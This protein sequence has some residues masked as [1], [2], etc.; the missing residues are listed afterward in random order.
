MEKRQLGSSD[1]VISPI[2]MGTWQAGKDMW[3]D[4]DDQTS[5]AAIRA[6]FDSGITTFDTAERYGNGHA[7]RI[8]AKALKKVRSQVVLA[9]KVFPGHLRREQVIAACERSCKNLQ[10]D[11]IDLYYIHW[12]A[13]SFGSPKVPIAETMEALC[14]LKQQGKIRAIG[15]SNFSLK[16]LEEAATYGPID[17]LQPPYSLF[18][19]QIERD[20]LPYCQEHHITVWAYSSLAQGL[21]TGK[22]NPSHRF[23]VGDH[24]SQNKLFGPAHTKQ[25]TEALSQ[26]RLL[27]NKLDITMGQLA[28]AWVFHQSG[29]VAIAGAR[30]SEQVQE[31]A[32]AMEIKLTPEILKQLDE[33]SRIV[34]SG[35]DAD[36]LLWTF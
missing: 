21:L 27:A 4:I 7:E 29:V 16:Q 3:T 2:V 24:R 8:L 36:T 23:T 12:P 35:F 30:S 15:V 14:Q 32:Q 34:T 19:R 18:W 25:V 33:I 11:W 17:S 9:S 5:I 28:L 10:S 13:G 1:I 6:A 20:I 22:F 26:L 31:N